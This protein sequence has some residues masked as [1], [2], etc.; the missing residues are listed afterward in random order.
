MYS[1][2]IHYVFTRYLLGEADFCMTSSPHSLFP[3]TAMMR[4]GCQYIPFHLGGNCT[5]EVDMARH[6]KPKNMIVLVSVYPSL[7]PNEST[8]YLNSIY[9]FCTMA[10]LILFRMSSR[11]RRTKLSWKSSGQGCGGRWCRFILRRF[12]RRL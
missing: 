9:V 7:V 8:N 12:T 1:P 2:V 6:K 10:W 4:T 11:W 5:T 3:T